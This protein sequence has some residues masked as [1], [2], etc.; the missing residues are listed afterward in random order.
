[1]SPAGTI[2][3]EALWLNH[4][5]AL[6]GAAVVA[7]ALVGTGG[8]LGR[9]LP[10]GRRA[11]DRILTASLLGLAIV[12]PALYWVGHLAWS[13]SILVMVLGLLAFV[14]ARQLWRDRIE[15]LASLRLA[16]RSPWPWLAAAGLGLA[17]VSGLAEPLGDIENEAVASTLLAG[18]QWLLHGATGFVPDHPFTSLPWNVETLYAAALALGGG[19]GAGVL[20]VWWLALLA[21]TAWRLARDLGVPGRWAP[22]AAALAVTMPM[23]HDSADRVR[24][25][26]AL[27]ALAL[28]AL[29]AALAAREA[30]T[31]LLAVVLAGGATATALEG[32][33]VACVT[34]TVAGAV[35]GWRRGRHAVIGVAPAALGIVGALGLPWFFRNLVVLKVPALPPQPWFWPLFSPTGWTHQLAVDALDWQ[36]RVWLGPAAQPWGLPDFFRLPWNLQM[37]A[38]DFQS[39]PP[40][41]AVLVAVLPGFWV[42]RRKPAAWWAFGWA[43]VLLLVWFLTWHNGRLLIPV[44]ALACV[45]ASAAFAAC[46]DRRWSQRLGL[47]LLI[48]LLIGTTVT[49]GFAFVQSRHDRLAAV[50]SVRAAEARREKEIPYRTALDWVNHEP[51]VRQV[52]LITKWVPGYYLDKPYVKI[53]GHYGES[54]VAEA[55]NYDLAIA[56]AAKLGCTHVLDIYDPR[57]G[58]HVWRPGQALHLVQEWPGARLF[59]VTPLH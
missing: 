12:G 27:A 46:D 51:A 45:V 5:L 41:L 57:E 33:L 40:G 37:Q 34:L 52:L 39:A 17:G 54:L 14:G 20:G 36:R 21:A 55:P 19:E 25:E 7:L 28:G 26:V 38:G 29:R 31:A 56:R 11:V 9:W 16:A 23:L 2:T 10:L 24:A 30:P 18:R 50:F 53:A 22:V 8:L 42:L 3:L 59:A 4:G 6:A 13:R 47:G 49:G 48:A 58:W 1:M 15:L 35:L 44:A 32:W 43:L